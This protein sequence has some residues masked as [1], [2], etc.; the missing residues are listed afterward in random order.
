[1]PTHDGKPTSG[2]A[3]KDNKSVGD[4]EAVLEGD[5]ALGLLARSDVLGRGTHENRR[6]REVE[7]IPR[8]VQEAVGKRLKTTER[9]LISISKRRLEDEMNL[10]FLLKLSL[11]GDCEVTR[12]SGRSAAAC[13]VSCN[14]NC[15]CNWFCGLDDAD[16]ERRTEGSSRRL[17]LAASTLEGRVRSKEWKRGVTLGGRRENGGVTVCEAAQECVARG[18]VCVP[19]LG[20][21]CDGDAG[22]RR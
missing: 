2:K 16:C 15:N 22:R 21:G 14:C 10:Q 1:L 4:K 20:F 6:G 3:S 13:C 17:D 18:K 11:K 9:M 19:S 5:C 12:E 8:G 7:S